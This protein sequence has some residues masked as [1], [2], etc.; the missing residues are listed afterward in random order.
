MNLT[1]LEPPMLHNLELTAAPH[2]PLSL[3][4]FGES[5]AL[6]DFILAVNGDIVIEDN[7]ELRLVSCPNLGE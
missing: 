2:L 3:R 7:G 4:P 5:Y 1:A 6:S